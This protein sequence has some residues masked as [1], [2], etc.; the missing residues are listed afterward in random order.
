MKKIFSVAVLMLGI[1]FT[2]NAQAPKGM[3]TAIRKQKKYWMQ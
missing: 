2:T 1:V 3:G